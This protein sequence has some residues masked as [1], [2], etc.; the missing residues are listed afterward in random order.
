MRLV[1]GYDKEVGDWAGKQLGT[2]FVAPYS[3][4][5]VMGINDTPIGAA[6]FNDYQG[7]GGNVELTYVGKLSRSA[8]KGI[9]NY[10]FNG[11]EVSRV[12]CKTDKTNKHIQK[13]LRQAGFTYEATLR[14][15]RAKGVDVVAYTLFRRDAKRWLN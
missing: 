15:Y 4:L 9:A 11:C 6:I 10:A 1:S 5:A 3:A 12:T 7:P 2:T 13:M 14:D 8:I